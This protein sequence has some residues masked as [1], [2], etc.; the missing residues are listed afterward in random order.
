MRF[1]FISRHR[2]IWPLTWLCKAL[3]VSRSC[4]HALLNRPHSARKGYDAR[5]VAA[6][7]VSFSSS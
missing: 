7:A 1:A 5:L 6:I 2:H 4:F 3:K